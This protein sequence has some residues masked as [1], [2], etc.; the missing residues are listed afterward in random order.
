MK[1]GGTVIYLCPRAGAPLCSLH[2]SRGFGGRN[3]SGLST[4]CTFP[5]GLLAAA[6]LVGG[7][8]GVGALEPGLGMSWAS[9]MISG[10][11]CRSG[12]EAGSKALGQEPWGSCSSPG[13]DSSLCLGFGYGQGPR[14]WGCTS[15]LVSLFFT[16]CVCLHLF[17]LEAGSG[18]GALVSLLPVMS[19][20]IP[21]LV[22]LLPDVGGALCTGEGYLCPGQRQG[23]D[24]SW[25][26]SLSLT[27][28]AS[29]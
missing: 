6:T 17:A 25:L 1:L 10:H 20:S 21:E 7:R 24:P 12:L 28:V 29:P 23:W 3:G 2:V 4:G 9:P 11:D 22:S 8:S 19:V 14:V 15:M 26:C 18:L 16:W 27:I 5:W 13:C